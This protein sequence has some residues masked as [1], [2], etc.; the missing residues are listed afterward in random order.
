M[1]HDLILEDLKYMMG[2]ID[3]LKSSIPHDCRYDHMFDG[4]QTLKE[5][6]VMMHQALVIVCSDDDSDDGE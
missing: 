1:I 4:L 6:I 2:Y 5:T 3:A